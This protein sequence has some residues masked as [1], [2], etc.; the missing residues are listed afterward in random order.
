VGNQTAFALHNARVL[1]D[2]ADK[3]RMDRDVEVARD[4]QNVL[5]P[6]TC[7][8][9]PGFEIQACNVAAQEVSGDYFDFIELDGGRWGLAIADVSGKGVPA[10]LIMAMCRCVLRSVAPGK[11]SA[12]ETLRD[13]NR[14]LYPDIREDMFITMV[15]AIL[16]PATHTLVLA[17]AGHE[18]PLVFRGGAV[19][20]IDSKGMP[21]GIDSG[22]VFDTVIHDVS[23]TLGAGDSLIL[24]TDGV[25]ET[26]DEEGREFGK[27]NFSEAIRVS[28]PEGADAVIKNVLERL[29]RFRGDGPPHD[30]VTLITLYAGN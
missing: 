23:V 4:I 16:D 3:Q 13:L 11:T 1:I 8:P 26:L 12:A 7:P 6:S 22:D 17:R 27:D 18:R 9:L 28:A 24:F 10:S 15:Y 2:L 14:R 30:D 29:T 5:L 25:T 20:T 19:E 21:L